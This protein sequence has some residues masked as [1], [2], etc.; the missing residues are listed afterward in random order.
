M[1]KYVFITGGTKT[2]I[3]VGNEKCGAKTKGYA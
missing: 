3:E 2:R 1:S